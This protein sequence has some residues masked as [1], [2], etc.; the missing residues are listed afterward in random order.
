M[1]PRL[2]QS[3]HDKSISNEDK[4]SIKVISNRLK[5]IQQAKLKEK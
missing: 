1:G 2:D 5:H 3:I 4:I